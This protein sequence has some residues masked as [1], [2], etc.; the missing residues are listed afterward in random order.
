M[1][2]KTEYAL[3]TVLYLAYKERDAVQ[4]EELA[5]RQNI[6]KTYLAKVMQDLSRE[7][8]VSAT[9]GVKGGYT[10]GRDAS[11]ITFADIFRIFEDGES[12]VACQYEQR[13]CDAVPGCAILVI[14]KNAFEKFYSDLA[15]TSIADLKGMA[16]EA[17]FSA[18]WLKG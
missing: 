11:D 14:V 15:Q 7:G 18:L 12:T 16:Q 4:L 13:D 9:P 10:L 2:K 3:H 6:S 17:P 8:I 1:S 5:Q